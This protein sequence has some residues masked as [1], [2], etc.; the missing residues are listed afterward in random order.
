MTSSVASSKARGAG[1]S[2]SCIHVLLSSLPVLS[3][4]TLAPDRGG[5]RSQVLALYLKGDGRVKD[6]VAVMKRIRV[7][8][9]E[10]AGVPPEERAAETQA[11]APDLAQQS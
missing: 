4:A 3:L 7:M 6:A 9:E 5:P 8:E 10:L 11:E 1:P 2:K